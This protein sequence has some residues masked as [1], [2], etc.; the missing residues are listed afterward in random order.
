[1]KMDNLIVPEEMLNKVTGGITEERKEYLDNYIEKCKRMGASLEAAF[2]SLKK[3]GGDLE[4]LLY[5]K[6]HWY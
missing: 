6:Q 5:L 3:N 1:M 4:D 2:N